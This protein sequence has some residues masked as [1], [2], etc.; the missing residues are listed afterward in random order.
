MKRQSKKDECKIS[1]VVSP[2]LYLEI[3]QAM[4]EE[5]D[6]DPCQVLD[7]LDGILEHGGGNS[8]RQTVGHVLK[9][10]GDGAGLVR[11]EG[12]PSVEHIIQRLVLIADH[13]CS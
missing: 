9:Q 5:V 4:N 8:G 2:F 6:Q 1:I 13:L 10:L 11:V 3:L 12:R 7:R